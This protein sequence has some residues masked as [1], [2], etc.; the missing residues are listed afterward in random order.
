MP[1]PGGQLELVEVQKAFTT[2]GGLYEALSPISFTVEGQ[3]VAFVGP[4]GSGKS[5]LL[6]L[7]AGLEE[8]TTGEATLDGNLVEGPGPDREMVF[9]DYALLPWMTVLDNVL[10]ALDCNAQGRSKEE[11]REEALRCLGD[12]TSLGPRQPAARRTLRGDEAAR[13]TRSH[14]GAGPEGH[15]A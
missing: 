12:G 15:A 3:F 8:P 2:N 11:R 7:V 14:P 6:R 13:G 9:Q 4:S 10:F 5:T 1:D